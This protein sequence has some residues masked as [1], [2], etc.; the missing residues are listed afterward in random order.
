MIDLRKGDTIEIMKTLQDNSLDMI[1][2]DLPYG[3]TACKWD[4]VIPF[5]ELWEQYRRII[6][7]GGAIVL[8][9]SQPF[10]TNLI[11]SNI[12]WFKYNLVWVKPQGVDPFMA[13]IRPLN[14]IEDVLIFC[15]GKTI[16]NPQK[17]KGKPYS[18]TRDKKTR[19]KETNGTVMR[20]TTTVN[21][22]DR[23]PTRILEF[24][25]Q[26]G[27]HPTQKPTELFEWL[28]KTYTNEG[29]CV[30]DNTM[31]SGTTG[32]ACI[33]TGRNFIG[34][35]KDEEYFKIAQERINSTKPNTNGFEKTKERGL[36]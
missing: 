25:Q 27:L 35:E 16:Y 4:A 31:G 21:E 23:L 36:F 20:E 2:C 11:A 34:I 18:I 5:N 17:T 33:N 6:K 30:L 14:N 22:G 9:A 19:I 29:M 1:L 28:I 8:T 13:K 10:T 26:K 15:D 12:E 3:T 32:V 7:K 24:K